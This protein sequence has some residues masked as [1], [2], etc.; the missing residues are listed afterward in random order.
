VTDAPDDSQVSPEPLRA[1]PLPDAAAVPARTAAVSEPDPNRSNL[2]GELDPKRKPSDA[3]DK[4]R[5]REA[6]RPDR[7]HRE[8]ASYTDHERYAALVMAATIGTKDAARELNIPERTLSGWIHDA[9][10]VHASIA[11]WLRARV[12][13]AV[14]DAVVAWGDAL[15]KAAEDGTLEPG[16]LVRLYEATVGHTLPADAADSA[17]NGPAGALAGA[18]VWNI[19]QVTLDQ[20]QQAIVSPTGADWQMPPGNR[21]QVAPPAASDVAREGG[22]SDPAPSTE[23]A[24][25]P[26]PAAATKL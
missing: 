17:G 5:E 1:A 23:E 18:Q 26:G 12:L 15:R 4:V 25:G 19:G 10:P 14:S 9:G 8:N 7:Q 6:R 13:G 2:P 20:R 3:P 21:S 24:D 16:H 22:V 11:A